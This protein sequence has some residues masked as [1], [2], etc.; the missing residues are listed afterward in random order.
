LVQL[1]TFQINLRQVPKRLNLRSFQGDIVR[2]EALA[3]SHSET[4]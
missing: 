4:K 1:A 3:R 2:A